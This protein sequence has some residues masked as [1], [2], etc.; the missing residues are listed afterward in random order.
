MKTNN[1]NV[2]KESVLCDIREFLIEW[3]RNF[4]TA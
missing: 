3:N 1:D 4:K 2:V